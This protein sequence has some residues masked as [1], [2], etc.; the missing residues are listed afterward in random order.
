M[1]KLL[2][3]QMTTFK[4]GKIICVQGTR[5]NSTQ[6]RRDDKSRGQCHRSGKIGHIVKDCRVDLSKPLVQEQGKEVPPGKSGEK[7]KKDQKNASIV[8]RRAT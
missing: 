3:W 5:S 4:L 6:E 7:Y 1:R 8:A 2:N